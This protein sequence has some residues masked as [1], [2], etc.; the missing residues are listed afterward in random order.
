MDKKHWRGVPYL[1]I[2]RPAPGWKT[3]LALI[4]TYSAELV[5]ITAALL[6]AAGL[7]DDDRKKQSSIT[8]VKAYE[9]LRGKFIVLVQSGRL[10]IP[11]KY[12]PLSVLLDRLVIQVPQDER[13]GSWHPKVIVTRMQCPETLKTE[14]RFWMGSRNLT[15]DIS[16]DTGI[17]LNGQIGGAGKKVAGLVETIT[18]LV[19]RAGYRAEKVKVLEAELRKVSWEMPEGV[20][21]EEI[22]CLSPDLGG[23]FPLEP[24]GLK[25]LL[26]VSPFLDGTGV[27]TFGRWGDSGTKRR[28][29][30]TQMAL[31]KVVALYGAKLEPYHEKL[32]LESPDFSG[33]G[34]ETLVEEN[35]EVMQA[36]GLHAKIVLARHQKGNTLWLG[37]A[38][39]TSRGWEGKNFEIV[40]R[41]AVKPSVIAGLTAF[42]EMG[43]PIDEKELAQGYETDEIEDRL[44]K[45]RNEVVAKWQVKHVQHEDGN[46]LSATTGPHPA[47]PEILVEVGLLISGYVTWPRQGVSMT[48]EPVPPEK[49]TEFLKVRLTLKDK[50]LQWV[51]HTPQTPPLGEER[52]HAAIASQLTPKGF[53]AWLKAILDEDVAG[54]DD[55]ADRGMSKGR[56]KGA[57]HDA[58]HWAPTLE[59]MLKAW[60]K[61]PDLL[62]AVH[63]KVNRYLQEV[64]ARSVAARSKEETEKLREFTVAWEVVKKVL[65]TK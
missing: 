64:E 59:S 55:D 4:T 65:L 6:A 57:G 9:E 27:E 28:L 23:G 17:V 18:G 40:A 48:L 56:K 52:D 43:I 5:A 46:V 41:M 60:T 25:E 35:D 34:A 33:E 8:F 21:V 42:T 37:S 45:G 36:R 14:W 61:N 50:R 22:T 11:K 1:D 39:A 24:T 2:L 54:T 19:K 10:A 38:N 3:N 26:V 53:L 20:Q 30:S 47:D 29:L 62:L 58:Q 13:T 16:W 32:W 63:D 12:L 49:Q 51:Q 44:E 31:K 15:S 7:D